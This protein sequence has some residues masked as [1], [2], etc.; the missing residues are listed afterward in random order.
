MSDP[1]TFWQA[2]FG[3][4]CPVEIE[5]GPGRGEVLL[6]FASARPDTNFFAIEHATGLAEAL[7]AEAAAR[8]LT[9]VRVVAGDARCVLGLA[10]PASVT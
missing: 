3:N 6:A 4:R 9:N 2:V 5:I 7:A 8:G 1:D 10:P